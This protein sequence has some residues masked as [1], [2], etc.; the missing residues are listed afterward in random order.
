MLHRSLHMGM[1]LKRGDARSD[2]RAG[3]VER[4]PDAVQRIGHRGRAIGP[5]EPERSEAVDL[6]EGARHHRVVGGGHKLDA[7]LVV[8]GPHI[9]GVGRVEHEEH[10]VGEAGAQPLHL[11]EGQVGAGRVVGVGD[12][13]HARGRAHAGEDGIDIR[14]EVGLRCGDRGRA[15]RQNRDLVNEEAVLAVDRL[16]A[17]AEIGCRE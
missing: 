7:G 5:A 2:G 16:I 11:V 10:I 1:I 15:A 13:D 4:S 9:F 12:E 8:V 3:D 6:G 14:G 17:R